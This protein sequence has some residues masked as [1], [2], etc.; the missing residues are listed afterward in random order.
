MVSAIVRPGVDPAKV[1]KALFTE[2]GKLR[3]KPVSAEELDRA[4]NGYEQGFVDGLQGIERRASLL[5]E[6]QADTGDP[7]YVQ[8]DLDRY[9]NATVDELQT[10]A[11]KVLVPDAVVVLTIVP[12]KEAKR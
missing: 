8:K 5:N 12:K 3:D 7:G 2:I 6:Y 1:E 10:Y 4:R 11:K 9:R